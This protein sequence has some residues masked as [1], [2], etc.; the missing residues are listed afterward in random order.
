MKNCTTRNSRS[1]KFRV[2]PGI[3]VLAFVFV[4]YFLQ[5]TITSRKVAMSKKEVFSFITRNCNVSIEQP[6]TTNSK[7]N[8]GSEEANV[9]PINGDKGDEMKHKADSE[10]NVVIDENEVTDVKSLNSSKDNQQQL[11]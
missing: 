11:V 6:S 8:M 9:S 10:E 1:S 7:N 3:L 5:T 2:V 4:N